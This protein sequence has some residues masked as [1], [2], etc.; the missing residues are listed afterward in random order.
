MS[1]KQCYARADQV[2]V[3]FRVRK[4]IAYGER[5]KI[6]GNQP[7][8]G[9]WDAAKAPELSWHD[10]DLWAGS[11][12]LPVGVDIEFKALGPKFSLDVRCTWG[13]TSNT[14][15]HAHELK[16]KEPVFRELSSLQ[17]IDHAAAE[18]EALAERDHQR[19]EQER[20]ERKVQ[21]REE[22]RRDR[23]QVGT[24]STARVAA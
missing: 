1:T 6:V 17:S 16:A 11:M 9:N 10:G 3:R 7:Q 23:G 4:K 19:R 2:P 12:E 24:C 21:E 8:L 15:V 14:D 18:A 22:R 5:F 13:N 20:R